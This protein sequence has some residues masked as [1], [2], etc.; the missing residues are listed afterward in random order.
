MAWRI[1]ESLRKLRDEVNAKWPTRSKASDG[2]IGDEAHASRGSD[3]NPWVKD[4]SVGIVTAIDITHDPKSGCDS[5]ALAEYLRA[6]RDG[7]IKYII[8]NRRI[9]SSEIKPWE[10]R[11]YH[12]ANPHDHHV[13]ISVKSEKKYY[14]D[15]GTWH[16][17]EGKMPTH[18]F[19]QPRP[20]PPT[21]RPGSIGEDVK[22]LQTLLNKENILVEVDG[23]FGTKTKKAVQFFQEAVG[24]MPDGIVGPQTWKALLE[25][26]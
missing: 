25:G 12:G 5:Y 13:H 21:L 4:G 23:N 22:K 18:E 9:C 19:T 24:L 20:V 10:W 2:S 17:S 14:D 1:A 3:H 8:S 6:T 26:E 15:P 11:P 16:L 7:R